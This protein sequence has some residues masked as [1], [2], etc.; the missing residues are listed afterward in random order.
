MKVKDIEQ[1]RA[2]LKDYNVLP[3]DVCLCGSVSLAIANIRENGDIDFAMRSEAREVLKTQLH[4]DYSVLRTNELCFDIMT[5]RYS[6]LGIS[7]DDL[8]LDVYSFRYEE[9]R[10]IRLEVELARKILR[11]L[12]KDEI[13]FNLIFEKKLSNIVDWN[14]V[15]LL[16]NSNEKLEEKR[17]RLNVRKTI[18]N[19]RNTIIHLFAQSYLIKTD[20][21]LVVQTTEL[22]LNSMRYARIDIALAVLGLVEQDDELLKAYNMDKKLINQ[23]Y[24]TRRKGIRKR[25]S[26]NARNGVPL[27]NGYDLA[28]AIAL[29]EGVVSIDLGYAIK[30]PLNEMIHEK[31]TMP[32]KRVESLLIREGA[33][34]LAIVYGGVVNDFDMIV[35]HIERH[36][37]VLKTINY[38]CSNEVEFNELLEAIYRVDDTEEWKIQLKKAALNPFSKEYGIILFDV[39]NPEF[40]YN[41]RTGLW[42]SDTC[43]RIKKEI[44]R[45]YSAKGIREDSIIHITDNYINNKAMIRELERF[46]ILLK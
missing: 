18:I 6:A 30:K 10:V 44:R 31:K 46:G 38:K 8:F 39:V 36:N 2:C 41:E 24:E 20:Y 45:C 32:I 35:E 25:I 33:Y 14:W 16:I 9:F 21:S 3:D 22:L 4:D 34:F 12:K 42:L 40:R 5:D 11:D 28:A 13:D 7:D 1:F 19:A 15:Y 27:G 43:A 29:N 17:K 26:I 37:K 23:E